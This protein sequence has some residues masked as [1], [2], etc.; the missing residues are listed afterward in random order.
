MASRIDCK[1]YLENS[2]NGSLKLE[3]ADV[4]KA[5]SYPDVDGNILVRLE[6]VQQLTQGQ[7]I[8][9]V[10]YDSTE[11]VYHYSSVKGLD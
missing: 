1:F 7:W 6:N 11:M 10:L 8:W 9:S 4:G 3:K 2:A 5:L